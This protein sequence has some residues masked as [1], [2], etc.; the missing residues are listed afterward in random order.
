MMTPSDDRPP[1]EADGRDRRLHPMSWLFIVLQQLKAFAIPVLLLFVTGRGAQSELIGLIG[2]AGIAVAAVVRYLTFR[3]RLEP[4]GIVILSGLLQRT[5]RDIPYERVHDVL[6]HRT[7][8]HR[9]FGVTEV[10]LESAGGGKAEAEMRVLALGDAQ[11]IEAIVRERGGLAVPVA[12]AQD[13][14]PTRPLVALPVG[15]V[16]KLG[17]ISNRGLVVVAAIAG[18]ALQ[19]LPDRWNQPREWSALWRLIGDH[20]VPPGWLTGPSGLA[21]LIVTVVLAV[22]VILRVFSVSLALLQFYGFTLSE[23]GRQLRLER[24]LLTRLRHHVPARRIQAWWIRETPL[25]RWFGRQTLT[26]DRAVR[27]GEDEGGGRELVPL[28]TPTRVSEIV[29]TLIGR[30]HWPPAAWLPLHPRAWR[31]LIVVPT[32]VVGLAAAVALWRF[33]PIGLVVLGV[34]PLVVVRARLWAAHAAYAEIPGRL[35]AVR[36]GWLNRSWR[37]TEIGKLQT[38]RLTESPFDRR[39]GMAT[40]WLDTAGASSA[41]PLRIP[42]LPA[43]DARALYTRLVVTME[44]GGA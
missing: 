28:A 15:E 37:F 34:L 41:H 38:V 44:G 9:L 26:V 24:G 6:L 18:A 20:P 21:L 39:H 10:R 7:V 31:R 23:A 1:L 14:L 29:A 12:E 2:I 16:V 3:F 8:L 35:V 17:L 32:L 22:V 11:A 30:E 13:A 25:H 27:P 36:E 5:R 33:G 4:N 43:A 42:Y 40:L 19:A